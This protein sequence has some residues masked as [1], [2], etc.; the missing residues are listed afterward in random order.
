MGKVD[1]DPHYDSDAGTNQ[2]PFGVAFAT[3]PLTHVG[4]REEEE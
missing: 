3:T 1:D 4:S 2:Q